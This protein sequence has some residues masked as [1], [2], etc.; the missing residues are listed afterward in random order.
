M[1]KQSLL[2]ASAFVVGLPPTHSQTP[3]GP[4]ASGKNPG[5]APATPSSSPVPR[6]RNE[7]LRTADGYAAWQWWWHYNRDELLHQHRRQRPDQVHSGSGGFLVGRGHRGRAQQ[8]LQATAEDIRHRALP[9]ILALLHRDD[10]ELVSAGLRATAHA[11]QGSPSSSA[12]QELV[13][14]LRADD[15]SVQIAATLALGITGAPQVQPW[16]VDLLHDTERGRRLVQQKHGVDDTLQALAAASLGLLRTPRGTEDLPRILQNRRSFPPQLQGVAVLAL[17]LAASDPADLVSFLLGLLQERPL[18]RQVQAQVPIALAR[19]ARHA[20]SSAARSALEPQVTLAQ[21]SSTSVD[22]QRS[23]LI[24]LGALATPEDRPALRVLERAHERSTDAQAQ[25][26]ALLS[27]AQI[28]RSDPRPEDHPDFHRHLRERLQDQLEQTGHSSPRAFAALALAV[29]AQNPALEAQRSRLGQSV[30]EALED[31]RH[32]SEVGALALALGL[33]RYEV[34]REHLLKRFGNKADRLSHGYLGEALALFGDR[35][36]RPHL[37]Q[38]IDDGK[39]PLLRSHLLR[40]LGILGDPEA[41]SLLVATLQETRSPQEAAAAAEAIGGIGD[42]R[43]ID[44]LISLL[45]QDQASNLQQSYAAL[46]LGRLVSQDQRPWNWR[47]TS[48]GNYR[49]PS[50]VLAEVTDGF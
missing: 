33:M 19:L 26:F 29:Y 14:A 50:P 17:G 22:L 35:R 48:H 18:D 6:G 42:R 9:Q 7:R 4:S 43:A 40:S 24:S 3:M 37:E 27:L 10:P 5:L 34:A 11:L 45:Q 49:L 38:A 16:L 46:A 25:H 30:A 31:T 20:G 1:W 8:N 2:I 39:D 44:A 28:G 12:L 41:L 13:A 23:L 32:G 15:H 47:Y 36:L 21:H